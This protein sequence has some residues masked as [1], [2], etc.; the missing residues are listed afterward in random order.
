MKTNGKIAWTRWRRI[1]GKTAY[2]LPLNF[3]RLTLS[4]S[5]SLSVSFSLSSML[6]SA[7]LVSSLLHGLKFRWSNATHKI[8]KKQ[9]TRISTYIRTYTFNCFNSQLHHMPCVIYHR[10]IQFSD[11]HRK[12]KS[13]SV[14]SPSHIHAKKNAKLISSRYI[15]FG[16]FSCSFLHVA[17]EVLFHLISNKKNKINNNLNNVTVTQ[18]PINSQCRIWIFLFFFS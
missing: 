9:Q 12:L 13:D 8:I 15:R 18:S 2:Y 14:R 10:H 5:L 7:L 11:S 16:D 4:L 17:V 1:R 3:L 6:R